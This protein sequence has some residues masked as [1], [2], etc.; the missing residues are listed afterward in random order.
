[1]GPQAVRQSEESAPVRV[2]LLAWLA[3]AEALAG[4]GIR[5]A[6][7]AREAAAVADRFTGSQARARWRFTPARIILE[8]LRH[9]LADEVRELFL[10]LDRWTRGG[11]AAQVAEVLRQFAK[12]GEKRARPAGAN[13]RKGALKTQGGHP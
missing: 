10:V 3:T 2:I 5:A 4:D 8:R 11:T 1:V 9:P 6:G 12:K 7:H 13:P